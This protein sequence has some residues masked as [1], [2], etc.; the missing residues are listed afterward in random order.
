[1]SCYNHIYHH[2]HAESK[3]I[4]NGVLQSTAYVTTFVPKP[5][6][7]PPA[8]S[9]DTVACQCHT[10]P[11]YSYSRIFPKSAKHR[12]C[13]PRGGSTHRPPKKCRPLNHF[14]KGFGAV[15]L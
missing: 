3:F 5:V 13:L 9:L 7:L 10:S 8:R 14:T 2:G 12:D 1:M 6:P 11:P 15:K 4:P